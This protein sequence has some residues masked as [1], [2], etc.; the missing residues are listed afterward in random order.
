MPLLYIHKS[1]GEQNDALLWFKESGKTASA[2]WPEIE[3]FLY[4]GYSIVTFDFRGLGETRMP[5][6]AVSPDDPMLGKLDF[7]HA[8]GNPLSG[9]LAN[10]VYNSLLSRRP[11]FFQMIKDAEIAKRFVSAQLGTKV[12]AVAAPGEA[13]SLAAASAEVFKNVTLLHGSN[14]VLLQW[15]DLVDKKQET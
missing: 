6:T 2:D 15:S 3:N 7:D 8:N 14:S 9:A 13:H 12:V 10:H 11:Y 1:S 4:S 5:Y